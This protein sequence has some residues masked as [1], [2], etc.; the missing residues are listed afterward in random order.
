[1]KLDENRDNVLR[2]IMLS[3]LGPLLDNYIITNKKKLEEPEAQARPIEV[4]SKSPV[5]PSLSVLATT[6]TTPVIPAN[7]KLVLS[8]SASSLAEESG[9]ETAALK[10]LSTEGLPQESE[11]ESTLARAEELK[12][13]KTCDAAKLAK[14][15]QPIL[16][17]AEISELK[18]EMQLSKA[19]YKLLR[20]AGRIQAILDA[21]KALQTAETKTTTGGELGVAR[22]EDVEQS[23]QQAAQQVAAND[24]ES[25]LL[26]TPKLMLTSF[27]SYAKSAMYSVATA[28]VEYA[29][30]AQL[31][32]EKLVE[33]ERFKAISLELLA[34][35]NMS[36]YGMDCVVK[37]LIEQIDGKKGQRTVE[38]I[39]DLRGLQ[40]ALTAARDR[41]RKPDIG[42]SE[43]LLQVYVCALKWLGERDAEKALNI[44]K[45]YDAHLGVA[46]KSD[47][48]IA[49]YG[50]V[51]K[52]VM[53]DLFRIAFEVQLDGYLTT[54]PKLGHT[55]QIDD[56]QRPL[57]VESMLNSIIDFQAIEAT[58]ISGEAKQ[59][60][61]L[62]TIDSV[63]RRTD[64]PGSVGLLREIDEV[65]ARH[66]A[67]V[68]ALS[69]APSV[70][71][72]KA[73]RM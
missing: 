56:T 9:A 23:A 63:R 64:I 71:S 27:A 69:N 32:R 70:S 25:S 18:K 65:L 59:R 45:E 61:L 1:M 21:R 51:S 8:A 44:I 72:T 41:N 35:P 46:N 7:D 60:N 58:A 73:M 28:V 19:Q 47:M 66:E 48:P 14:L 39:E 20:Q 2:Y 4:Q 40:V 11:W 68:A 42:Y 34:E 50:L 22:T 15:A 30:G 13:I 54:H 26:S 43:Q 38:G 29:S 62:R 37:D 12:K 57:I 52:Q 24:E 67:A 5:A 53:S 10:E 3:V 55:R 17:E 49:G 31:T 16:T 33:M 36:K 6:S